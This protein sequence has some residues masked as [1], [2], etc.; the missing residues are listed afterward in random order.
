[1]NTQHSWSEAFLSYKHPRVLGMLF[2][3]FSAGLPFLLVFSTLSAWLRDEG[4]SLAVIGFFGWVG[5]TYSLK[6]FW[7][8]VVDHIQ[9]PAILGRLGRRRSWVLLAQLGIITGL[10]GLAS[11]NP[12]EN[13]HTIIAFALLVAFSSAT[14]DIA[15]DA[16]RIEAVEVDLQG[17]MATTYQLGYRLALLVAGG[18]ALFIAD[19]WSWAAAYFS[20]AGFMLVGVITIFIVREPETGQKIYSGSVK[21]KPLGARIILW[22]YRS[23]LAPFQDFFAR[24]GLMAL[25]ILLLI[26]LYRLPDLAMG[27]MA[28][29]FYLDLG[30]TK[31]EIA[32]IVKLYGFI[33]TVLGA[34]I[35]G[36]AVVRFG[37]AGPLLLGAILLSASNLLFAF[38]AIMG[39]DTNILIL[40][41]SA[42]NL[43][44]G[45]AGSVFI[46]YL[47]SLT[48]TAYTATQYALFSSLMTLPGKFLS[49]FSGMVV[50]TTGY[51]MFFT[52]TALL[53]IPAIL[54]VLYL[55]NKTRDTHLRI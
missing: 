9:L 11:C 12:S 46:A 51:A 28:N 3:G 49:G 4:I 52:L 25:T 26:G 20:M 45:I 34:A 2:L 31:T 41:I 39:A 47:S 14:Q 15:L 7:A 8:P 19:Y 40:T 33:M 17:N 10:I 27:I 23:V 55:I 43:S 38:L 37:L 30:F 6:V 16:Y 13:L 32:Q 22:F 18:G 5:M 42:D 54:L 53:G 21:D 50:E 44:T 24:Y 35:G 36:L 29:P 48:N 1:M